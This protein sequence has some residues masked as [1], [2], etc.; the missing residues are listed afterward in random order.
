MVCLRQSVGGSGFA[1]VAKRWTLLITRR[2]AVLPSWARCTLLR[3]GGDG[4]LG[5]SS[6]HFPDWRWIMYVRLLVPFWMRVASVRRW[7]ALQAR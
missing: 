6:E 3:R 5:W 1:M 7:G 4:L 2:V